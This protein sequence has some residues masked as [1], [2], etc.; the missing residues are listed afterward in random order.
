MKEVTKEGFYNSIKPKDAV[1]SVQGDFPYTSIFSLRNNHKILGKA[2]DSYM[3]GK[4]GLIKTTYYL[5]PL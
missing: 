2:V 3:N 4:N 5:N 1:V